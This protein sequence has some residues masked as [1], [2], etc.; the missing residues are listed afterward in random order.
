LLLYRVV[1]G[2]TIEIARIL[3]DSMDLQRHLSL[4]AED[5]DP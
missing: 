1:A 3:H 4:S 2:Q 5:D